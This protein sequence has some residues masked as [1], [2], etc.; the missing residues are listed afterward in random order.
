[1][2]DGKCVRVVC[3]IGRWEGEGEGVCVVVNP[4]G[5]PDFFCCKYK[6]LI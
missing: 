2:G 5:Q 1:M 3:E 4:R 6:K